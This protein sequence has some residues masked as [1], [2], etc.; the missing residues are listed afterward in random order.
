MLLSHGAAED[1]RDKNWQ[2]PAHVAAANN[3]VS[4]MR[5]LIPAMSN[6]NITDRMGRDDIQPCLLCVV[7][8]DDKKRRSCRVI[9]FLPESQLKKAN[10]DGLN[11]ARAEPASTSRPTSR[12]TRS[13]IEHCCETIGANAF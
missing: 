4:C 9:C 1:A 3:A 2:T 6:V 12:I 7:M 5:L 8:S 11:D 13:V 10:G